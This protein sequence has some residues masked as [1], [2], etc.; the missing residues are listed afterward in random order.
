VI[1]VTPDIEGAFNQFISKSKAPIAFEAIKD[2]IYKS[3]LASECKS[4]RILD[5]MINDCARLLSCIP[6]KLYNNKRLLSEI[7]VL[8]TALNINYRLGKLKAKE[9]ESRNS[10][11]YYVKKDTN[12]DDIYDEIKENYKNH[13]VPL[14]LES[15]LL[16]N[17][18]LIDTIVNGL[19][20]KDKITKS[21][22]NSR[23]FIKPESKGP[24]FTILNFD[25][26]PTTD[27]DNALEELYKQFEEMQ[28]IENGEI[29]HS[30]N[31]LFMLSEAKHID[32][33]IDDI[34]LFFLEYVRKLQKNNKFPPADLFTE[35]E[36]I[37]DSAY[38]YGYWINDSYKHYSSKLNK[39][40]AQ[41]QQIA[42]RKRY[43][44]FLA[45]LRNNLK[46][47]TAKF[48]EQISRNGLKDINIYG[49][50]AIL[51]S[52]KP[53]EFVDMWLSID[54]T[55]WHNVRTALV[56]R[57]SGGSLHGDLTDEGP[58][59]KFVKMNIRHRASK[60]SG[61][62]KLRISRLLIGL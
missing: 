5:Y 13:E 41:Q 34:Y 29:Q 39:I 3:F 18:V 61:I 35:Y 59:L 37:R 17:E 15:D 38:G 27:V 45:D 20:D 28:I 46:E 9:I 7:F 16:S 23:H 48:C 62:D 2:I 42:L 43:P 56:N 31:L 36:P 53:H 6:D 57:Y 12:A 10:V 51:S 22:D 4:L 60:A 14:R 8:F 26:Y 11:L 33:T 49:Y 40:L 21:I 44:Q 55:N 54:M 47:D 1:K 24:W 52:F 30:I 19:Y 58:W 32:K 25:L 50:I